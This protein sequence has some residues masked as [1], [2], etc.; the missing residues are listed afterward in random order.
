MAT[1]TESVDAR[2]EDRVTTQSFTVEHVRIVSKRSFGDV[3]AALESRVEK[4]ALDRVVPFITR[5]DMAGA[6]AELEKQASP[7]GRD[8]HVHA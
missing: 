7:A 5:G 3:R 6:R 4:L 1:T 2:K 8:D